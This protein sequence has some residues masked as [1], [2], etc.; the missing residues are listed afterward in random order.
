MELIQWPSGDQDFVRREGLQKLA[1]TP[2]LFVGEHT[3]VLHS[4]L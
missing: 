1:L 2:R 4:M 3:R